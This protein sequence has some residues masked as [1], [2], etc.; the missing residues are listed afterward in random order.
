[1][2]NTKYY[3]TLYYTQRTNTV[4]TPQIISKNNYVLT[5]PKTKKTK[6]SAPVLIEPILA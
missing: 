4:C 3:T 1:M 6:K 2:G 5:A